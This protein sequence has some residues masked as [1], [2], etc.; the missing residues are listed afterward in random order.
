MDDLPLCTSAGCGEVAV[1]AIAPINC[2]DASVGIIRC[3]KSH[4]PA[5]IATDFWRVISLD[6]SIVLE[7]IGS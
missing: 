4:K 7:V 6:E 3:C 5:G 1:L 2:V